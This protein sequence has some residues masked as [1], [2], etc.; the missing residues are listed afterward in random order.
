MR[1]VKR[2]YD[3]HNPSQEEIRL[4]KLKGEMVSLALKMKKKA[5]QYNKLVSKLNC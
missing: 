5:D 1:Y 4:K 3:K 2:L